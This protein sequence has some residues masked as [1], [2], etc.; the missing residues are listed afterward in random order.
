MK[1]D[2]LKHTDPEV[3]DA[4]RKETNRQH[5]HLELIASE[6]FVSRAVMQASGS[7]FTNKY[8]EGLPGRR[9]YEGCEIVDQVENLEL[10]LRLRDKGRVPR[11][12]DSLSALRQGVPHPGQRCR[13][14]GEW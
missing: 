14:P 13:T 3:F 10:D 1:P 4:V 6:N 11:R 2:P 7:V 12:N 9:Y 8:S 5:N